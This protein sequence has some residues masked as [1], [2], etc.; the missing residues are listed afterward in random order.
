MRVPMATPSLASK[1]AMVPC[2]Y[3]VP[4][5]FELAEI[6]AAD[7]AHQR[8]GA[9]GRAA[10]GEHLPVDQRDRVSDALDA[11]N[12]AGD[13][14]VVVERAVDRRHHDMAVDA[15]DADQQF[16]A[17]TVHDRHHDDQRGDAEHDAG[18]RDRRDHRDE[19]LLAARP[20]IAPGDEALEGRERPGAGFR[21]DRDFGHQDCAEPADD[22]GDRRIAALAGAAVLDLDL[23]GGDAARADDHLP[24]QADQVGGRELAAGALVGVVVEHVPARFGQRRVDLAADAVAVGIA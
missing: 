15:E 9:G 19:G 21:L 22:F 17:E 12:A 16:G 10:G 23:A 4:D 5:Q 2:L 6:V 14:L 24:G 20:E 7:A 3:V 1:P 13:L 11:G 18:K 8:T